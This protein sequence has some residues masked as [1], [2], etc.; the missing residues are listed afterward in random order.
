VAQ[1]DNATEPCAKALLWALGWIS[2]PVSL[3]QFSAV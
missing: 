3:E 2:T 1:G